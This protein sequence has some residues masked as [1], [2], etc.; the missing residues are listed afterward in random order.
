MALSNFT[1]RMT[2]TSVENDTTS[3][4]V[5]ANANI[6][7]NASVDEKKSLG[8]RDVEGGGA[9]RK[10]SRV[11][12]KDDLSDTD[13]TVSI[14]QQIELEKGNSIQYRTCSWQKV[15][16]FVN[17]H[18]SCLSFFQRDDLRIALFRV[19]GRTI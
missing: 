19:K 6:P 17:K 14:G 8:D 7:R 1:R 16:S 4:P 15:R 3:A 12:G 9:P 10:M 2:R 11:D 18:S 5:D 13:S